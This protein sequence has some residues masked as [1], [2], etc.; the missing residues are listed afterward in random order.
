MSGKLKDNFVGFQSNAMY[1]YRTELGGVARPGAKRK[2]AK[3]RPRSMAKLAR[4][5]QEVSLYCGLTPAQAK[6]VGHSTLDDRK[7][8][9]RIE[10]LCP[11]ANLGLQVVLHLDGD[12][13][14]EI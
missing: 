8:L 1:F 5:A 10:V 11:F 9:Q 13:A 2:R 7:S 4:A 14:V 6:A 12:R 3:I